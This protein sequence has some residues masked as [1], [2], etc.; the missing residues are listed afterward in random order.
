MQTSKNA[1]TKIDFPR[2]TCG[3]VELTVLSIFF[4][5]LCYAPTDDLLFTDSRKTETKFGTREIS[6]ISLVLFI[7]IKKKLT[8]SIQ[9]FINS[10]IDF[11][12]TYDIEMFNKKIHVV[13]TEK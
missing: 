9:K 13:T 2:E 10:R 12:D 11:N 8:L 1:N 5:F 7:M 6:H 4:S 3:V